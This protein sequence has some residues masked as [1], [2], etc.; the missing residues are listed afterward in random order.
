ML[1]LLFDDLQAQEKRAAVQATA[2]QTAEPTTT[3]TVD[4]TP[5]AEPTPADDDF[6]LDSIGI[7][8]DAELAKRRKIS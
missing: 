7:A 8:L 4:E 6:S 5:A 1:K 2:A 3:A